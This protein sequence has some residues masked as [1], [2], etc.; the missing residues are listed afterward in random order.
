MVVAGGTIFQLAAPIA[1]MVMFWRQPDYFA[2]GIGGAWLAISL[3]NVAVYMNDAMVMELPLVSLGGGEVGHDWNTML[4]QFGVLASA[5]ML[6]SCVRAAAAI[7]LV[8]SL[9]WS[10]WTCW[11]MTRHRE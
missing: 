10:A 7:V 3:S 2:V 1:T 11:L 9:A 4:N 8:L 5:P 6:A